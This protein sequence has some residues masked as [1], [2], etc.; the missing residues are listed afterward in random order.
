MSLNENAIRAEHA[1]IVERGRLIFEREKR[2]ALK[3]M[4]I[5]MG[6]NLYQSL[7]KWKT[8]VNEQKVRLRTAF[9]AKL[10]TLYK[11]KMRFALYRWCASVNSD[12]IGRTKRATGL[13]DE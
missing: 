10:V 4:S 11:W 6:K 13:F 12:T 3:V 2:A 7:Q 5:M 8:V 9:R 1:E